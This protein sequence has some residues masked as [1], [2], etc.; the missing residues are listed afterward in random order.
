MFLKVIAIRN[1]DVNNRGILSQYKIGI[2][3]K[4]ESPTDVT[5]RGKLRYHE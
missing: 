5:D 4:I 2:W 1:V 3:L